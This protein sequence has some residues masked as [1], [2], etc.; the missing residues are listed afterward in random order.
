MRT[1]KKFTFSNLD[2]QI[3]DRKI[4]TDIHI[5][6][7]DRQQYLHYIYSHSYRTERLIIYSQILR[8]IRYVPLKITLLGMSTK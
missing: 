4:V 5:K 3:L 7:P 6:V 2:V 1:V 8:V